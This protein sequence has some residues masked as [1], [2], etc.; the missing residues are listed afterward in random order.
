LG[1]LGCRLAYLP[2]HRTESP[3]RIRAGIVTSA[4]YQAA[5]ELIEQL[6]LA[7]AVPL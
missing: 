3:F 7:L 2:P 6:D 1:R 4:D 5:R